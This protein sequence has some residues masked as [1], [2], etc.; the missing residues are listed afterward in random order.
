[1]KLLAAKG[2]PEIE[3]E[4]WILSLDATPYSLCFACDDVL[5]YSKEQNS[6]IQ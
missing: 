6:K 1:M 5:S 4:E 3:E 2:D